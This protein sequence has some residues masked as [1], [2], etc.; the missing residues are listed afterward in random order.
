MAW[1]VQQS[2]GVSTTGTGI[3]QAIT[4]K[5]VGD[6]II[7][8]GYAGLG[9]TVSIS[10]NGPN[11]WNICNP[12]VTNGQDTVLASWY[13]IATSLSSLTIT[14]SQS[15]NTFMGI[16]IDEFSGNAFTNVLDAHSEFYGVT[17]QAVSSTLL[18]ITHDPLLWSAVADTI[19]G[20][21]LIGGRT[22]FKASDDAAQDWSE[23]QRGNSAITGK[24]YRSSFIGFGNNTILMASFKPYYQ[25][26]NSTKRFGWSSS[27][28]VVTA[29][30]SN[31]FSVF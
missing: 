24:I 19:T 2:L 15:G 27:K 9:S 17:G 23:W 31:F 5:F 8:A 16:M 30:Q 12:P 4:P 26:F 3:S 6:L 29:N 7:V 11:N 22:A 14:V 18:P 20:V 25:S 10:D 21:G 1:S 13:T 28:P